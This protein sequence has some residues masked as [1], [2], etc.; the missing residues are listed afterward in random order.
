MNLKLAETFAFAV[1]AAVLLGIAAWGH[2][3]K[4]IAEELR[5]EL[6]RA[7][8]RE[9]ACSDAVAQLDAE[10]KAREAAA[11]KALA[12][13]RSEADKHAQRADRLLRA[14]AAVPGD[15]CASARVRARAW[16][17]GRR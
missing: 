5:D 2:H 10:A 11:T 12:E 6:V 17:E 8:V 1:I 14:P 15:D 3:H 7:R 16:L 13:A 4:E 9:Q